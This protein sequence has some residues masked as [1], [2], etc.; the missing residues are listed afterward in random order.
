MTIII[1][2]KI[3]QLGKNFTQCIELFISIAYIFQSKTMEKEVNVIRDANAGKGRGLSGN[4]LEEE[5]SLL[6]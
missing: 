1:N 3:Y 5:F 4:I 6:K 2:T